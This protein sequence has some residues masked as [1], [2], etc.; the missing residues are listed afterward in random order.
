VRSIQDLATFLEDRAFST[1][2]RIL[3]GARTG[4][5]PHEDGI[6]ADLLSS[7]A[8]EFD[9]A[10]TRVARFSGRGEGGRGMPN[11]DCEWWVDRDGRWYAFRLQAKLIRFGAQTFGQIDKVQAIRLVE[12]RFRQPGS[13]AAIYRFPLYCFYVAWPE[14]DPAVQCPQFRRAYGHSVVGAP[15]VLARALSGETRLNDLVAHMTPLAWVFA[16]MQQ[17]A[18]PAAVLIDQLGAAPGAS[19]AS[20]NDVFVEPDEPARDFDADRFVQEFERDRERRAFAL[21]PAR[22]A[23]PTDD[24]SV[25]AGELPGYVQRLVAD[26]DVGLRYEDRLDDATPGDIQFV[27]VTR[28]TVRE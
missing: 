14:P 6:T 20:P 15:P 8:A 9:P 7:I 24:P 23:P 25:S 3:E 19:G 12:N 1:W 21:E 28:L 22:V 26:M 11:A 2:D 16:A 5:P 27:A 10:S 13:V 18:S 4:I 17:A